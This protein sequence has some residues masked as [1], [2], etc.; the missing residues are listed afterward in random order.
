MGERDERSL[1]GYLS[2]VRDPRRGQGRRYP[3]PA[4]LGMLVLAALHGEGS[5]RGMWLWGQAHW[6]A[7]WQPLGFRSGARP[8][9]LATVWYLL[10]ALD[11]EALRRV[12]A[13]WVEVGGTPGAVAV[14]GKVLRGSRRAGQAALQ[15]VTAAAEGMALQERVLPDEDVLAGA[16]ALLRELPLTDRV[17]TLDAGLTQREV[18]TAIRDRGGAYLGVVKDNQPRVK[19]ALDVWMGYQLERRGGPTLRMP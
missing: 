10:E 7:I 2:Q 17:V 18:L 19:E 16:L 15:L 4:V 3:L 11:P 1:L 9:A 6:G 13:L 14:D 12:L 5:L 8:P